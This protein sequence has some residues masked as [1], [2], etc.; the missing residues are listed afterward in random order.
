MGTLDEFKIPIRSE[1]RAFFF[2]TIYICVISFVTH[3][4]TLRMRNKQMTFDFYVTLYS[5]K[6]FWKTYYQ[7]FNVPMDIGF[8]HAW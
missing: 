1:N 6:D 8:F 7:K 5:K 3:V 2:L 4:I